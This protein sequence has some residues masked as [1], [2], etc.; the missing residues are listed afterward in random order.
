VVEE[1]VPL[2][3]PLEIKVNFILCSKCHRRFRDGEKP[4]RV[5]LGIGIFG[6]VHE[7]C[8]EVNQPCVNCGDATMPGEVM[9]ASCLKDVS[10]P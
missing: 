1:A 6:F 10:T 7:K 8:I 2:S 5:E 3:E 4:V 9:C